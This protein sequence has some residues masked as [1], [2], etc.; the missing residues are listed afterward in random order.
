MLIK[1]RVFTPLSRTHIRI[2]D[3]PLHVTQRRP[4]LLTPPRE[5]SYSP[6]ISTMLVSIPHDIVPIDAK[7]PV[8]VT[9][10]G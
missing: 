10:G 2:S 4:S 3:P 5:N 6:H 7:G 1:I 9:N 8:L